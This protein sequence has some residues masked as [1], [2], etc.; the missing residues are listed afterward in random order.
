MAGF[1]VELGSASHTVEIGAG[2]LDR[3]GE[4]A[5]GQGLRG[6]CAIISD[7]NVARLFAERAARALKGGG[8]DPLIFEVEP[9]ETSKSLHTLERIYDF[10]VEA[11]FDRAASIF[12]LGG[13]VV[14]DLA[15][16][17]AATFLRGIALVQVPT[18]LLAQ[19]DSALG[20]KTAINHPLGKNLIGAVYQPR[21]IVAD[22]EL[23]RGLPEREFRE[24]IA[25]VIKYGAILDA[26]FIGE[27]ERNVEAILARDA[28]LLEQ[29]VER[30]L[31]LKAYVVERDEHEA[32]LRTILNFGHTVGHAL[33]NSAGYGRYLHGEA[34]AIGMVAATRLSCALSGLALE[35]A[36]RLRNLIAAYG[37]PV[38]M[39]TGWCNDD[40]MQALGRDKKR[41][42]DAI[43]FVLLTELGKT[44]SRMLTPDEILPYLAEL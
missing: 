34:V 29:I 44:T 8:L 25:E 11:K 10:L 38:T 9:G 42:D 28:K 6:R 3:V 21:L 40:F 16:F 37:L 17:A 30:C 14:G 23:L 26:P 2:L 35:S 22:V 33:E 27:L 1:R 36:Q 43:R 20:G 13:G 24:G 4:L 15:G 5:A 7:K 39:P 41:S 31:R 12:A 32:A 19:V 18:T